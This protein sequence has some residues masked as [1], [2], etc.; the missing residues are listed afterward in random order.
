[1]WPYAPILARRAMMMMDADNNYYCWLLNNEEVRKNCIPDPL[2][3]AMIDQD[4]K[5]NFTMIPY[6]MYMYVLWFKF[7]F[8]LKFFKPV[9]IFLCFRLW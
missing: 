1:M 7:I 5:D 9:F 8:G 6:Y 4:L 3:A 2:V